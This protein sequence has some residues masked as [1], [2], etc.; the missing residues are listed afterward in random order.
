MVFKE[1]TQDRSYEM[2]IYTD[3]ELIIATSAKAH[4]AIKEAKELLNSR[5][6]TAHNYQRRVWAAVGGRANCTKIKGL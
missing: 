4:D 3:R 6:I 2:K 5:I 1:N